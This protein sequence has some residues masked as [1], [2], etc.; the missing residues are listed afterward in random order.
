MNIRLAIR[1]YEAWLRHCTA[2]VEHQLIDKH[3][4]MRKHPFA[5][6]RGTAYRWLQLFPDECPDLRSAPRVLAIGDA[7]AGNYATWRDS[8]GRLAWGVDDFDESSPLPY[9]NDL[10]RLA[11]S[12]KILV[13]T[14]NLRLPLRDLCETILDGYAK[15]LD[16]GGRPF[17]LAEREQHL[18]VLGIR[19]IKPPKG[20]WEELSRLPKATDVPKSAQQELRN[21]L[22]A[23]VKIRFVRRT[24]GIGSLGQGRF[25]AL[26]QWEGGWIAREAKATV[27]PVAWWLTGRMGHEQPYYERAIQRAIRAHDPYQRCVR[28]W[29]IRRLSPD[30]NPIDLA[31]LPRHRDEDLLLHAMGA[32]TANVHLGSASRVRAIRKDLARRKPGWLHAAAKRMAKVVHREWKEYRKKD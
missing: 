15:T 10:V 2:V 23:G 18:K 21:S 30:A 20:F 3:A 13:D 25:V 7:H 31:G 6:L 8:E 11:A 29:I 27:P 9:T 14:A 16:H 19:E 32:E 17:V 1:S 4:A 5:F 26:A 12:A 24:A 22:P 28:G